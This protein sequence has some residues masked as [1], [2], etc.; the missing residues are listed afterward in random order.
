MWA[1]YIGHMP[2]GGAT[3][4]MHTGVDFFFVLSGYIIFAVH[5]AASDAPPRWAATPC[6]G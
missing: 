1:P 3:A 5:R 4:F 6:A 2:L